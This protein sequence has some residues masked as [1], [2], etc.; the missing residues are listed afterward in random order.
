MLHCGTKGAVKFNSINMASAR[1]FLRKE[2][3]W[4]VKNGYRSFSNFNS[5]V[6]S[7]KHTNNHPK[8]AAPSFREMYDIRSNIQHLIKDYSSYD[9]PKIDWAFLMQ[10]KPPLKD[11]EQYFL[12][13]KTLNIL[14]TLTCHRLAALQ[15]LPY[16]ALVNP[17]IEQSNRLYLKTLESLLSIEYPYDLYDTAKMQNLTKEFLNDHQDTLLTLSNGL[18]EIS[19]FYDHE[20]IFKFLNNHLHDRILMKLLTTNYL[21]LLKQDEN[22]RDKIGVIHKDLHISDLVLRTNEFVND[23]TFIKYD[24]TVPVKF[25]D[26]ADVKFSYIPTDL[27]YVLQEVLKNSSRAHIENNVERE[28]EVTIVKSYEQLEIR[29]RDFGGGINPQVE[30]LIFD[31]SFSTTE[32]DA[33]DTGM[34]AYILPGQEVQNVAGM[35]FGLPMCKAYLELFNGTLDIQSLWGWGTDVY[36]KLQGPSNK[37][38]VR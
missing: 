28:V 27:E 7:A 9:V 25:M 26:G 15:E 3:F 24:K 37:L 29:I 10:H 35:G 33:K 31:Y 22:T 4:K 30:D 5:C 18:Q 12:T 32:K 36:I 38:F 8:L 23:L 21:E 13:I 17:N 16:I 1:L 6:M 11:N 34:S 14:L 2:A 19:N 20:K